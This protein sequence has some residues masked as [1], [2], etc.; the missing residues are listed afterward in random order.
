MTEKENISKT[1]KVTSRSNFHLFQK[2][3]KEKQK[4]LNEACRLGMSQF[5]PLPSSR[6]FQLLYKI[7]S[8]RKSLLDLQRTASW[9]HCRPP[10]ENLL[11]LQ[12]GWAWRGWSDAESECVGKRKEWGPLVRRE[13]RTSEK[14][15][16]PEILLLH[17]QEEFLSA[18]RHHTGIYKRNE[19]CMVLYIKGHGRGRGLQPSH[20][21]LIP[22]I[23]RFASNR[24]ALGGNGFLCTTDAD[25]RY[26]MSLK[27]RTCSEENKDILIS[28]KKKSRNMQNMATN[29]RFLL[30]DITR[31][32]NRRSHWSSSSQILCL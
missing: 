16:Y 19:F 30:P 4:E 23:H 10:Q 12:A 7:Q 22:K 5:F 2:E 21:S 9:R 28:K 32:L 26:S 31:S 3:K 14:P 29:H 11:P 24:G 8:K 17:I 25:P 1:K 13:E 15:V 20:F 18:R 27:Y 6:R